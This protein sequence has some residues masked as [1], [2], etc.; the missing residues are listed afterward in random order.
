[1]T[2]QPIVRQLLLTL[3]VAAGILAA[4]AVAFM[5]LAEIAETT[6]GTRRAIES[7]YMRYDGEP[8]IMQ[9]PSGSYPATHQ[10][11]T[12]DR[13][14]AGGNSQQVIYP[15]YLQAPPQ[16]RS[17]ATYPSRLAGANDGGAPSTY[18][19]LLHDG[20]I[21]GRAYGVGYDSASKT[22][23]GYFGRSGFSSGKPARDDW[24]KIAGDEG[25]ALATPAITNTEPIYGA[26]PVLYVLAEGQL[27]A[28]DTQQRQVKSLLS[29]PTA[30]TVGWI[31]QTLAELPPAASDDPAAVAFMPALHPNRKLA[32]RST[33]SLTVVDPK[34]GEHSAIP[35]PSPLQDKSCAVFQRADGSIVLYSVPHQG[36]GGIQV[37]DVVWLNADGVV[38]REQQ[39]QIAGAYSVLS[40]PG[41][42]GW[43][44]AIAAPMPLANLL[45]TL[46]VS[47]ERWSTREFD[48][49]S[50][51]FSATL[52]DFWPGTLALVVGSLAL[53]VS[54]YRRQRHYALP[55]AGLWAVFVFLLGVPG[56]LAYRF[57]RT[58]PVLEDCPRCGESAPRDRDR[59]SDCGATFPPPELKGLEIYA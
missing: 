39:V 21:N 12:L 25:V 50:A 6:G 45:M 11:L 56:Y 44:V 16:S 53:A 54:A 18:W 28:I 46:G 24:F 14:P 8:V 30:F 9:Y 22:I 27:W 59:C 20:R 36:D 1:M 10:L 17:I 42:V 33:E 47:A 37:H 41:I 51:A 32:V 26:R 57:H 43:T 7:L 2:K 4:W 13:Q 52:G 19:Y 55:Y 58:W 31:S 38:R 35:M 34:S 49:Y 29:C 40:S 3:V 23:V 5:W 15:Q 48:T